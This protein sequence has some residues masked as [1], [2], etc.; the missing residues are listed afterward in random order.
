MTEREPIIE[1]DPDDGEPTSIG[2]P[3]SVKLGDGTVIARQRIEYDGGAR[4]IDHEVTYPPGYEDAVWRSI[5]EDIRRGDPETLDWLRH[6]IYAHNAIHGCP[7]T[8]AL[9]EKYGI[10]IRIARQA[11][12]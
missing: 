3:E 1:L 4:I 11:L 2:P 8:L 5:V 12:N 6:S 7:K 10:E 9:L